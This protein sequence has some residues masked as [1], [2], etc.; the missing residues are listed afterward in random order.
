MKSSIRFKVFGVFILLL[1]VFQFIFLI[2]NAYFLDDIFIFGNKKAMTRMYNEFKDKLRKGYNENELI[3][4]LTD[5]YGGHITLVDID[6]KR[7][8]STSSSFRRNQYF[9]LNPHILKI[10]MYFATNTNEDTLFS[11]T[12]HA[13]IRYKMIVF[14]GKIDDNKFFIVEKPLGVINESSKIAERF[15][16]I[17]G[18]I[19]LIMGSFVVFF[20]SGTLTKPIIKIN[21]VAREIANLNFDRKVEIDRDDEL[22]ALAGSINHISDKLSKTLKEL[23]DA[24][25][26]LK[27]D[28]KRERAMEKMR[29]RFVSSVSHELKTPISMIQGYAEGLKYNIVKTPEDMKYYCNVI[30]DESKKMS[31]LIKDLLDL[32][33]YESGTFTIKKESFD[34]AALVK[35]TVEK[36]RKPLQTKNVSLAIETPDTCSVKADRIRIEQVISNFMSNAEK[37]VNDN[38][39]IRVE[40]KEMDNSVYFSVYNSGKTIDPSEMENIWTSFYKGKGNNNYTNVGTGLGL[41]IVRAIAELHKGNYGVENVEN[42]VRFWIKLPN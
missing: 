18:I 21:E 22:G 20:L 9:K 33:S 15:I 13:D 29:R 2:I 17:S 27:E 39:K 38:G 7:V 8:T 19:T 16:I 14:V 42:G 6:N 24:N 34:L 4:E 10:I 26:K 40:L 41:A 12:N 35:E 3:Y 11:V 1:I 32:S 30:I 31:N 23:S 28:I 5:E 37:Y 25:S 36:Y